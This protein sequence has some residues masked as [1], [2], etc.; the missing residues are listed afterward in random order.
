MMGTMADDDGFRA[1]FE[2]LRAAKSRPNRNSLSGDR[3]AVGRFWIR[4]CL[5]TICKGIGPAVW[6]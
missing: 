6:M 3:R 2:S 4:I 5:R 1:I